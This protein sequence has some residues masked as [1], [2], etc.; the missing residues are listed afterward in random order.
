MATVSLIKEAR[1]LLRHEN[2]YILEA[3]DKVKIGRTGYDV[4]QRAEQIQRTT[5]ERV[6]ILDHRHLPSLTENIIHTYAD[7]R[8][9]KGPGREWYE[10]AYGKCLY[11]DVLAIMTENTDKICQLFEFAESKILEGSLISGYALSRLMM[12]SLGLTQGGYDIQPDKQPDTTTI[13]HIVI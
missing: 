4:K 10:A 7:K 6:S 12:K 8:R 5:V 2:I 3:G 13:G 1:A 9:R 11:Y